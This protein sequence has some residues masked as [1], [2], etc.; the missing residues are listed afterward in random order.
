MD[1]C[2]LLAELAKKR[3]GAKWDGYKNPFEYD[4]SYDCN[5]WVS[6]YSKSAHNV[7]AKVMLVLQ[8]W[9]SDEWLKDRKDESL[10][11]LGYDKH[12]TTN[13]NLK[14]LLRNHLDLELAD[15]FVT[16]LFPF[17]K[18]GGMNEPIPMADLRRAAEHFAFPQ[19][20]IIRPRLVLSFGI[21]TFNALRGTCHLRNVDTVEDAIAS[22]FEYDGIEYWGLGHPGVLGTKA[23]N[24]NDPYQVDKDWQGI[25]NRL[26]E[27]VT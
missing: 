24:A 14:A 6:P 12:L 17:V 8:D 1:K 23:R 7:D 4:P 5:Q 22:P 16:N 18:P 25:A 3:W 20:V 27:I 21:K 9:A 10:S 11:R 13:I 19:I 2:E 15:V 26:N